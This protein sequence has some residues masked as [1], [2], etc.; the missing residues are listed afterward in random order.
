MRSW[1]SV[2]FLFGRM[3]DH[4]MMSYSYVLFFAP[5]PFPSFEQSN[6]FAHLAHLQQQQQQQ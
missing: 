4:N 1:N 5:A 6:F 2:Q 3:E